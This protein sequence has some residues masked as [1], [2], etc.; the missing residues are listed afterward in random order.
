LQWESFSQIPTARLLFEPVSCLFPVLNKLAASTGTATVGFVRYLGQIALLAGEVFQSIA[1]GR[2]RVR[3]TLTQL[4]LIGIGSQLVVIITGAFTGAVFAAQAFFKFN[5][6]GLGSATGPVVSVAMC[7][8]LGP[9]LT[10]LMV[11]GR[12]GAAIAAEIGTMRVTEQIDALRAMGVAPIDYLVVPR[13]IAMLVSMPI[14]VGES[15]YFGVLASEVLT[16]QF[17]G[18]PAVWFREQLAAHT[19]APDVLTGLTKAFVFGVLIVMISCHQGLHTRDGAVGVGRSTTRA[20]VYSSLAVLVSNLFL[21]LLLNLWM[22]T[23]SID[24]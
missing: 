10:A 2:I 20:V 1:S 13:V 23:V 3:L 16:V 7:R 22:P 11:S 14:L 9:V 4:A 12:V 18:V 17:F 21:S 6:L 8:E 19:G 15:I 5:E 24:L